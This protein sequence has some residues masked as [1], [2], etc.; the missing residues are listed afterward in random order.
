MMR[1]AVR[2]TVILGLAFAAGFANGRL[3]GV[4]VIPDV[5][6]ILEQRRQHASWREQTAIDLEGFRRHFE[7]GFLVIDARP[8]EQFEQ[9]HLDAPLVMNIPAEEAADGFH[10]DRVMPYLGQPIVI[11][12]ASETCD[13]AEILWKALRAWGFGSE[14]RV[15]HPGW[16]GIV[17]AGLPTARGPDATVLPIRARP[18]ELGDG[19]GG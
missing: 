7:M 6:K 14:L 19:G 18:P 15:F 2:L 11:Y 10:I 13:S 12:C 4:P 1:R 5:Q 3:R 8:R 16:E 17:A 9:G